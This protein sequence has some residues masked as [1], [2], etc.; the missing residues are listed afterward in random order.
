MDGPRQAA[1]DTLSPDDLSER[2][3]A[4]ARA[5]VGFNA[6]VARDLGLAPND[7]WALEHLFA[8][9]EL[10]PAELAARLGMTD[11]LGDGPRRPPRAGRPR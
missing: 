5:L 8:D 4:L 9:G 3:R 6:A 1:P 11:R 7:V 10:G 2:V